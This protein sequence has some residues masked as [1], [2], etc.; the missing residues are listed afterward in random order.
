MT[1]I[2]RTGIATTGIATIGLATASVRSRPSAFAGTAAA[3]A[4]CTAAVTACV[5]LAFSAA[6]LPVSA[7]QAELYDVGFAF[8]QLAVYLS[9]LVIGQ[10]MSLAVAQRG[11][12]S[13][14]LRAVGAEPRQIRR[15][16]ATE[17]LW[18]CVPVLPVGYAL[19]VALAHAWLAVL[20]ANGMTPDGLVLVAGW[21]VAATTTG[22]VLVCSQLGARVGAWRASRVR[23]A[24]ALAATAVPGGA[25]AGRVRAVVAVLVLAGAA[26][27]TVVAGASSAADAASEVPIVLLAYLIGIGLAGPWIGWSVTA[28]VAPVLLRHV[29][30][31][32]ELAVAGCRARSRRLSSAITPVAL[33]TAFTVV[34]LV[35]MT[36]AGEPDVM[37][38]CG[39]LL[40]VGFTGL[41]SASTLVMLTVE[42]LREISLLR[43][44]GAEA[45]QVVAVVAIEAGVTALAGL[46]TG[47]LAACAVLVPLGEKVGTPVSGLPAWVWA[48]TL[49]CG[50]ALV[51]T[52]SCAPLAR[53][54]RV[55][56]VEGVLRYSS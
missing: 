22:V 55:R 19:G 7:Q 38:V 9:V 31:A 1:G 24:A 17:A 25:R 48:A 35:S 43:T 37:A 54:L 18:T 28:L 10:V 52:A 26:G 21:P 23:P 41:V 51:L 2:A 49:V 14:L 30:V 39:T 11:R 6:R 15:M 40:F 8:S 44:V 53:M 16:V 47:I 20:G 32:G 56:A 45:R 36:G 5:T 27:L 29:G 33:V 46:G 42:R 13:A 4:C 3:L 34:Q 50:T 12:E